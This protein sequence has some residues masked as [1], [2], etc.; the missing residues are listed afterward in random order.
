MFFISVNF[1]VPTSYK[2]SLFTITCARLQ[3]LAHYYLLAKLAEISIMTDRPFTFWQ[4]HKCHA[5]PYLR[6]NHPRC[7]HVLSNGLTCNH[8]VCV[9][10]KKDQ[11]IPHR[12]TS[13][14]ALSAPASPRASISP[15]RGPLLSQAHRPGLRAPPDVAGWW[16]CHDCK[17]VNNP[18]FNPVFCYQCK[19]H[20]CG[21]CTKRP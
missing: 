3:R 4:C 17:W 12:L 13:Q 10:C 14:P 18:A 2:N 16:R 15:R 20:R 19:H 7:V 6:V 8:E 9:Y 11:Q 1:S 5:G 21:Y